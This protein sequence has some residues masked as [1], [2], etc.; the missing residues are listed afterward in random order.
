LVRG[1]VFLDRDG[2]LIEET[3]YLRDPARLRPLP[4]A[5]EGL[6]RLAAAGYR[7]AVISNQ[8]GLARG[9]FTA[10][11]MDAVHREFVD[12]F[13]REGVSFDAVEYCP[14]HPEGAVEPYREACDCRKPGTG[15]A[16]RVLRRLG[17]PDACPRWVVGD[18]MTDVLMGV[19]LGARTILVGTGYGEREKA[20]GER[21]GVAPGT[22]LPGMRE[23]ADWILSEDAAK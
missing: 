13:R 20:E 17:V 18:K 19:R 21:L 15:L 11:E 4:G 10:A 9:K 6:R 12:T 5:A 22:F 23:A 7:L 2:T 3:G 8:A 16:D 1:I 14:H